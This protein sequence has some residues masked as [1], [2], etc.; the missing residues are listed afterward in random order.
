MVRVVPEIFP[1]KV[2][3]MPFINKPPVVIAPPPELIKLEPLYTLILLTVTEFPLES[4]VPVL[5]LIKGKSVAAI[6]WFARNVVPGYCVP[7]ES[8]PTDS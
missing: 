1:V 8:I 4:K 2:L 7:N 5:T 6:G 3:F